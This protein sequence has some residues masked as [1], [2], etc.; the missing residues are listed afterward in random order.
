MQ[1]PRKNL[2]N[3]TNL[4]NFQNKKN[5]LSTIQTREKNT[6][7]VPSALLIHIQY[8]NHQKQKKQHWRFSFF[9]RSNQEFVIET[10]S[11]GL[12]G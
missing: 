6:I 12:F 7:V 9:P 8:R 5:S 3:S 11:I 4:Q 1:Y 2:R 10:I